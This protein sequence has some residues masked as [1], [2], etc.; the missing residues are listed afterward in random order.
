MNTRILFAA[1]V[2]SVY[3]EINGATR[4][5]LDNKNVKECVSIT[6]IESTVDNY[7]AKIEIHG[8]NDE[9]ITVGGI[10]Y[11]QLS[12]DE[13]FWLDFVGEPALPIISR[14]VALPRGDKF[15]VKITDE[16]WSETIRIGS[17]IP[18]QRDV[19]ERTKTPPPFE[20]DESVYMNDLFQTEKVYIGGLQ[21]WRDINNRII[22]I[23]PIKYMPKDGEISLLKEFVFEII[24]DTSAKVNHSRYND[25]HL[26]LNKL[27]NSINESPNK[28]NA[29]TDAY[30]YLI[31]AGD[32]NGILESQTLADFQKWKSFKGHKTKVVS[33]LSIGSTATQIKNYI[34]SE[35]SKG[36]EYVLFIG[37]HDKIPLYN[38]YNSNL[39][40][41]T[42]SDYWY[43]C[44]DGN[45]DVEADICI[46][47]FSTNSLFELENMVNKTIAYE[48]KAR[49]YGNKVLLVAHKEQAPYKYQGCSENIR[50]TSYNEPQLFTTAYG[51]ST[52]N[53]GNCATNSFVVS[54]INEANNIIN[55]RGHGDYNQWC[56]WNVN[57][58]SFYD[59]QI[60]AID[61]STNDIFFC[62]ACQNGN[63]AAGTCFMETFMRSN[64]GA[65]GMI[66]ATVDTYTSVNHSYDELLFEKL[67]NENIYNIGKLNVAAHIA[68]MGTDYNS[69]IYNAFSYLCGCD[70]SLEIITANTNTFDDYSLSRNGQNLTISNGGI[71]EY[72]VSFVSEGGIL[73]F[74]GGSTGTT[75][76]FTTPTENI[77]IVL[78]KHNYAPRII[79]VDVTDSY[80]QN[81]VFNDIDIDYYYIKND[82]ISV[83]YD[84]TTSV[85]NGNVRVNNSSK[86]TI[87]KANGVLIKNGFECELGGE[88]QIK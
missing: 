23:C 77:Y 63:I 21:K 60:G 20:K 59:T 33:T 17:I 87:S 76:T 24:F 54:K 35:Y 69:A 78:N 36:I 79:Y 80:I 12:F 6:T 47:R 56:M 18:S 37:D 10:T 75:Y 85:T 41:W 84:V 52:T 55:Y 11:H 30:D 2:L 38:Y 16:K 86:L 1:I 51:A 26:F 19:L 70:P 82:A 50:T 40:E 44:M 42:K 88:L 13:P 65:A 3:S 28:A 83:G 22:N 62:V 49:N 67:L 27:D 61:N 48:K 72:S 31:I 73:L 14:L 68:N 29:I 32:I 45:N 34:S 58:E 9:L 25:M 71:S 46:G 74:K 53:G 8:F 7:K 64:H 81:K 15:K 5:P 39:G 66:A 57:A 4:I 43:G